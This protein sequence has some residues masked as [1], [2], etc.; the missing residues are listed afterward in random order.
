MNDWVDALD[1]KVVLVEEVYGHQLAMLEQCMNSSDAQWKAMT[2]SVRHLTNCLR[3]HKDDLEAHRLHVNT[4][5]YTPPQ[6]PTAQLPAWL[7]GA[8]GVDYL[9]I[10]TSAL[11]E[12]TNAFDPR[13][14]ECSEDLEV[15]ASVKREKA[16]MRARRGN[17]RAYWR[18][19]WESARAYAETRD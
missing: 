7:Y 1:A 18:E 4:T 13:G 16:Q 3:D 8:S 12:E 19:A 10:S 5:A 9:G 14:G 11:L 15:R 2:S 17:T 6:H